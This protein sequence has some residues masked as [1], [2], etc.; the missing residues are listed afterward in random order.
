MRRGGSGSGSLAG[1]AARW[2]GG[3]GALEG[4]APEARRALSDDYLEWQLRTEG[5]ILGMLTEA[6]LAEL[7]ERA[8]AI[9]EF[10][11]SGRTSISIND[12]AS[13]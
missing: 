1:L 11:P 4:L 8:P 5:R 10:E 3:S 12:G 2:R 13:F 6:Q 7:R 9:W